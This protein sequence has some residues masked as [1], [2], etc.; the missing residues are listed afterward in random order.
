MV[1]SISRNYISGISSGMDTDSLIS[2]MLEAA[3]SQKYNLERKRNKVSYQQSML[4]EVNLKLY[5]LQTKATDLTFSKTYTS[6]TVEST[7]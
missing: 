7:A 1:S 2:Q 5:N 3:S 6:K 4:Q